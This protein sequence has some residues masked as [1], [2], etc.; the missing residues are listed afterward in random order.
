MLTRLASAL[1]LLLLVVLPAQAQPDDP[2]GR[3]SAV[4]R[5][6]EVV[7]IMRLEGL[8]YGKTL[9]AQLFPGKGGAGWA[10]AVAGL[11]DATA[12][13]AD[14]EKRLRAALPADQVPAMLAFFDSARGRRIVGLEIAARRALLSPAVQ[15]GAKKQLAEMIARH[16]PKLAAITAFAEAN[17]LV[18]QN[19]AS[20]MN[21]DMAFYRG[22]V[23]GHADGFDMTEPQIVAE[24][25][26][27]QASIRQ[28]TEDWLF[29]FLALAYAPLGRDDLDAYTAFSKTAAGRALNGALFTAFGG[30]F[31]GISESL[32][33]DAARYLSGSQL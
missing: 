26:A 28:D 33:R 30:T 1:A 8:D 24:V 14:F 13:K 21:S 19:V 15:D 18:E 5:L 12:L 3:L 22:L 27:Q 7:E 10:A 16:D 6:D 31:G 25:G 32:G 20:T 29:P 17:D 4:L 9:E 11:Y 23:A 2:V